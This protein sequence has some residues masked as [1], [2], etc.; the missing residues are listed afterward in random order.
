VFPAAIEYL[1]PARSRCHPNEYHA[2]VGPKGM[3][4]KPVGTGPYRVTQHNLGKSIALERNPD[5]FKESQK[6]SRRSQDRDPL[7]PD[8]QTQLAELMSAAPI[9]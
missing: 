3:N 6:G 9:S 1:W 8:R 2:Q 4:E 5:Y 7:H